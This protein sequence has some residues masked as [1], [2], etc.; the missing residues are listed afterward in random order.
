MS[1]RRL[2]AKPLEGWRRRPNVRYEG[3]ETS[4]AGFV[5]EPTPRWHLW[6][7]HVEDD[8]ER[9]RQGLICIRCYQP[10]PE[11]LSPATCGL[12]LREC[13]PFMRPDHEVVRLVNAS[14]CPYCT[15]EVS[16]EIAALFIKGYMTRSVEAPAELQPGDHEGYEDLLALD[17]KSKLYLPPGWG[18]Q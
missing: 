9:I 16:P 1:V 2:P 7:P 18:R 12:I 13:G 10:F 5:D 3:V 4:G 17:A 15:A 11:R 8:L 14:H 6:G